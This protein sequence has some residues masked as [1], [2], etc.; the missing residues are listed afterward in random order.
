MLVLSALVIALSGIGGA[1]GIAMAAKGAVVLLRLPR[2]I[3]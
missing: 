3:D 1:G 2:L